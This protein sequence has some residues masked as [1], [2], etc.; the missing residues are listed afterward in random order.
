MKIGIF[1]LDTAFENLHENKRFIE[2]TLS[3]STASLVCAPELFNTGYV[4]SQIR[5]RARNA[6]AILEWFSQLATTYT[7]TIALGSIAEI[8]NGL[9]YN[10][11]YVFGPTGSILTKYRK[12]HLFT[13]TGEDTH[14]APGNEI[15]T[16][17]V[18]GFKIGC[19]ICYDLRFPELFRILRIKG[20]DA[21]IIPANW[22][23][24]RV[25]HWLAL[26][27]VRA[28]ENQMY[29]I[30]LNRV[31]T[32]DESVF[33][34]SSFIFSPR[35]ESILEIGDTT[36]YF[37][38]DLHKDLVQ[39]SRTRLDSFRDRKPDIYAKEGL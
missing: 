23:K 14:F 39:S 3:H 10:T 18:D 36:G 21:V 31:G 25:E 32:D 13:L 5:E 17:D 19:A 34:G 11:A 37:E 20:A 15:V 33:T 4:L 24:P 8:D 6:H 1:Q 26:G 7:K 22:P 35:G 29:S 38:C 16:F 27:K 9:L 2:S 28:I 12:I 30:G